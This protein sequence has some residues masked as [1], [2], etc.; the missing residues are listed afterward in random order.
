MSEDDSIAR[1]RFEVAPPIG[2]WAHPWSNAFEVARVLPTDRWTMVGGLM[3][4]AHALAHGIDAVRPTQ[5]VDMLLHVQLL[6]GLPGEAV[7]ALELLGYQLREPLQRK[8][9]AYRFERH[10]SDG[11]DRVDVLGSDHLG[12]RTPTLRRS[13]MLEIPGGRQAV[14]RTASF[15]LTADDGAVFAFN[16]PDELGALVLKAAAHQAD[17]TPERERH[18]FDAAV[19]AATITDHRAE[20]ARLKGS[21]GKRLRHVAAELANPRH[22]AWLRLP[23]ANRIN[24]QDTL[25]ILTT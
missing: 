13:P 18:L 4:Q 14:D 2:G 5:D 6:T 1:R 17:R 9:A 16:I 25:R 20:R 7:A 23:E 10:G 12:H 8:G 11:V 3:V 22:P 24:G 19:L 15:V 21:D